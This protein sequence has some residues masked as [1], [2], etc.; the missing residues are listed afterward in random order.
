M[1]VVDSSVWVSRIVTL[2]AFHAISRRW[3][4]DTISRGEKLIIPSLALSETAGAVARRTGRSAIGRRA[5]RQML[6]VS[7]VRVDPVD[8]ALAL[9]AARIAADHKIRGS[10]AIYV[11]L[12]YRLGVPLVTWD[13]EQATR[14]SALIATL[15]PHV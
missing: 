3:I 8:R 15:Q 1:I 12:A 13:N 4:E 6:Q 9:V 7:E 14:A 10:D 11:A 5:T 2:D